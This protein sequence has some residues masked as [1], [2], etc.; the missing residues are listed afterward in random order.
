MI[1][2]TGRQVSAALRELRQG[3]HRLA[4]L[5]GGRA[6]P[7]LVP[8]WNRFD[9]QLIGRLA[10]I[11]VVGLSAYGPRGRTALASGIAV[12][13]THVD[14]FRWHGPPEFLGTE[15]CLD[16]AIGHLRDRRQGRVDP[17]EPTGVLTHH[18]VHDGDAWRFLLDFV[19]RTYAHPAVQWKDARELFSCGRC[20]VA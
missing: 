13:N 4:D 11:G 6:L 19:Q 9:P 7:V 5:F 17:T 1:V 15:Y 8:P 16:L 20:P 3:S 2:A 14:I 12:I 18:L 10:E